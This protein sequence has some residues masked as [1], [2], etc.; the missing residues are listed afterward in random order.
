MVSGS[1]NMAQADDASSK[2]GVRWAIGA[3]IVTCLAFASSLLAGFVYDDQVL[4]VD[5]RYAQELGYLLR[6]FSTHLWDT[7]TLGEDGIGLKYYRPLVSVSYLINW[8]MAGGSAWV[9]HATN[10]AAHA[11]AVYLAVRVGTQWVGSSRLALLAALVFALH[12]T[13]TES[14]VWIAGRTDVLMSLFLLA[15]VRALQLANGNRAR[16]TFWLVAVSVSGVA[17]LLCKELAMLLPGLFLVEWANQQGNAEARRLSLRAVISSAAVGGVY[18]VMR[19]IWMPVR[20]ERGVEFTPMHALMTVGYY[21][22]RVVVPWPQT[23]FFRPLAAPNGAFSYSMP[24]VT[25]GAAAL[26][27]GLALLVWLFRRDRV[28]ASLLALSAAFMGPLLNWTYTG[29]FVSSS[30]HFLYL[31]LWLA[32]LVA[33][34]IASARLDGLLR[35]RVVLIA[36]SGLA[37]VCAAVVAVR[38]VECR[39]NETLWERELELNPDNPFVLREVAKVEASAG[40]LEV[41]E[42]LFMRSLAP[43]SVQYALLA[44]PLSNAGTYFK[45]L[46]VQTARTADGDVRA[47]SL[48][49]DEMTALAE[50]R[51]GTVRGRVGRLEVGQTIKATTIT[52]LRK[53]TLLEQFMAAEAALAASRLG[54]DQTTRELLARVRNKDLVWVP[55]RSNVVL[56]H[57]R[58]GDFDGARKRIAYLRSWGLLDEK[59]LT[60]LE[61][62]LQRAE[63]TL[64]RAVLEEEP[65]RSADTALAMA[66]LGAYLRGLRA[67]R[68]A[69]ERFPDAPGLAPQYVQL[70]VAAGLLEEARRTMERFAGPEQGQRTLAVIVAQI[71]SRL[72]NLRKVPEPSSWWTD[73]SAQ[74]LR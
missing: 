18:L 63:E 55:N 29:I 56:A 2:A 3:A 28:A 30:D 65:R 46:Q 43:A 10:V 61:A 5:N 73:S 70:L 60:A 66:D 45:L 47:L 32:V 27:G 67:L 53:E 1:L 7:F 57:A 38:S 48:L 64:R 40:R 52:R 14:V 62:R 39:S 36:A 50:G 51:S 8:L 58:I 9:F 34:R 59:K 42:D 13:R 33:A 11:A 35:Q 41:A 6:P 54:R 31:P 74:S 12:P 22:E 37:V 72:P 16:R 21:L 71:R 26:A 49:C 20:A 68:P 23:F 25:A 17:A 15:A 44:Q 69:L 24:H 19:A 4:I